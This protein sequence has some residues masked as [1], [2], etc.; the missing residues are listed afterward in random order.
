MF[1]LLKALGDVP[2]GRVLIIGSG[3]TS[4][5]AFVACSTRG[6]E[7]T[8][9]ARTLGNLS[10]QQVANFEPK[11]LQSPQEFDLV[12]STIPSRSLDQHLTPQA[13]PPR[14]FF[15]AAYTN[16]GEVHTAWNMTCR[17]ISGLEMLLW[18]AVAQQAIFAGAGIADFESNTELI[19][20]MRKSLAEAVGE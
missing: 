14:V 6:D 15:S 13:S 11:A 16:L 9:W 17:S 2:K 4:R 3:A 1:G 12:I 20:S 5:S 18:Q 7:V 10:R 8:T 19:A